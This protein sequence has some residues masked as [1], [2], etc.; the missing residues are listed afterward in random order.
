[1]RNQTICLLD[2]KPENVNKQGAPPTTIIIRSNKP[3]IKI[4]SPYK[5]PLT[6]YHV[7]QPPLTINFNYGTHKNMNIAPGTNL[8]CSIHSIF[9]PHHNTYVLSLLKTLIYTHSTI[10]NTTTSQSTFYQIKRNRK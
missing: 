8:K 7:T 9:P 5:N 4:Y 1:M 2:Y 3:K 6:N 10:S